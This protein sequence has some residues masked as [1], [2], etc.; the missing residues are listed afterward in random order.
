MSKHIINVISL[1]ALLIQHSTSLSSAQP[2]FMD[3]QLLQPNTLETNEQKV[4]QKEIVC[5]FDLQ[6]PICINNGERILLP[7]SK[8]H[9]ILF[10]LSFDQS[11]VLDDSG[12]HHH[13]TGTV[14]SGPS[15]T[16]NGQSGFFMDGNYLTISPDNEL[17]A[18]EFSLTF[19]IFL[20]E[21]YLSNAIDKRYCPLMQKGEENEHTPSIFYDREEKRLKIK[22]S[23]DK[24][25]EGEEIISISKLLTQR[26]YHIA[27]L[28]GDKNDVKLY[29]NGILDSTLQLKGKIKFNQAPFYIGNSPSTKDSCKYPF[30]LDQI[31]FYSANIK[32]DF[33][34]AEAS[35]S[36]GGLAP[37][38]IKFGCKDCSLED[39][40]KSCT[41]EYALC[42]SIEL[43]TGGYQVAR[44]LGWLNW[45]T[46]FWTKSALNA[47]DDYKDIKGLGLCCHKL[48]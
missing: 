41:D 46:Y 48:S 35:P 36:L 26:W 34:Q 1:I 16:G 20:F 28:K 38:F 30:L 37:N 21:D 42:S 19:W 4:E 47:K 32:V 24:K 39:A 2:N 7:P 27:L 15:F 11:E 43:H 8:P 10:H 44:N 13:P 6:G 9:K 40:E 33:V 12:N 45:D 29:V 14:K 3:N 31:R 23:T 17:N 5:D 25:S 22:I 18:K